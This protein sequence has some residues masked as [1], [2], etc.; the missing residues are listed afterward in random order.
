MEKS[1]HT[2]IQNSIT[3]PHMPITKLQTLSI[4]GH[5][6]SSGAPSHQIT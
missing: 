5:P 1:K 6:F 3:N 4:H 2:I